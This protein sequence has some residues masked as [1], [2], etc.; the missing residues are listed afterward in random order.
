MEPARSF[1]C[2]ALPLVVSFALAAVGAGCSPAEISQSA[3]GRA[4]PGWTSFLDSRTG[5]RG[6]F[7]S[8]WHRGPGKLDS[9]L[10]N[11][12]QVFTV[13]TFPPRREPPRTGCG[14]VH[15][16][17]IKEVGSRG[18]FVT[19]F[20]GGASPSDLARMQSRP[21]TFRLRRSER[22]VAYPN[23]HAYEEIFTFKRNGRSFT[24]AAVV[25]MDAPRAVRHDAMLILDRLR[26]DSVH[27][28]S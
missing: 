4:S 18:A 2:K 7:P 16:Q 19:L 6:S 12:R 3:E 22:D 20:V 23:R 10:I 17:E 21:R 9:G 15:P 11:P 28:N 25:G 8:S 24:A 14:Y 1:G 26:L 27:L 13:A 5:L